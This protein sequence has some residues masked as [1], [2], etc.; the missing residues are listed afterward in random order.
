MSFRAGP[1]P[2]ERRRWTLCR[3]RGRGAVA[4][5]WQAQHHP[6]GGVLGQT[7]GST[8]SVPARAS[9]L[10]VEIKEGQHGRCFWG[11]DSYLLG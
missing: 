8:P 11:P 5:A 1:E 10:F 6:G 4:L 3:V 7:A 9:A 2:A